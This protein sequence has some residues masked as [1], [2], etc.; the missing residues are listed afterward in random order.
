MGQFPATAELTATLISPPTTRICQ[1]PHAAAR[2]L[3]ARP[4]LGATT[5]CRHARTA[6]PGAFH[7]IGVRS[8]H[9][10]TP[11]YPGR[12]ACFSA[13]KSRIQPR[14]PTQ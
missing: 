7:A 8:A 12:T 2:A 10:A 9:L 1:Q 6:E 14:L 4:G 3:S 13:H 5:R 11:L